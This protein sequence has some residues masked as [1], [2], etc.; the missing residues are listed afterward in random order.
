MSAHNTFLNFFVINL[1]KKKKQL[2]KQFQTDDHSYISLNP[3]MFV[4]RGIKKDQI[5]LIWGFGAFS[6]YKMYTKITTITICQK[7]FTCVQK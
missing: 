7:P 3:Q 5:A 4:F 6:Y 2:P 1:D